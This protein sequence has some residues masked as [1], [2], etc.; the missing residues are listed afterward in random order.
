MAEGK[1]VKQRQDV[2][3]KRSTRYAA[4]AAQ[5][6]CGLCPNFDFRRRYAV[7]EVCIRNS[8]GVRCVRRFV[9]RERGESK[10]HAECEK[11]VNHRRD[12]L[13]SLVRLSSELALPVGKMWLADA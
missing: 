2:T 7:A 10:G 9:Q 3:A 6:R 5:N 1:K 11:G 12:R 4:N 13:V 8:T